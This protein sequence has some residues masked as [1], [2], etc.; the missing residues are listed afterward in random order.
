MKKIFLFYLI[1][2]FL[3]C[4]KSAKIAGHWH[5]SREGSNGSDYIVMDVSKDS[6]CY[7][8]KNS[9]YNTTTGKHL[10]SEKVLFFPGDCGSMVFDYELK[11]DQL[12][13]KNNYGNYFG[14]KCDKNCCDRLS[15]F[16]HDLLLEICLPI[17]ANDQKT[18]SSVELK[19]NRPLETL[20]IGN[21]KYEHNIF[22]KD[23][24]RI[25]ADHKIIDTEELENWVELT[26]ARHQEEVKDYI[27]YR[28]IVDGNVY[29]NE[30][31]PIIETLQQNGIRI[32]LLTCLK[33]DFKI[34][35]EIFEFIRI[36][37]M[38]FSKGIRLKNLIN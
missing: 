5:I 25:E 21:L 27:M 11:G 19:T 1:F 24:M 15:D 26:K 16:M 31:K 20:I 33:E 22:F 2:T 32:I 14:I 7:L 9:F 36:D 6:I 17:I 29:I 8:G 4:E 10:K 37:T 35:N 38:D 18:F 30:L 12:I 28:L 23:K 34:E 13:L 3:S